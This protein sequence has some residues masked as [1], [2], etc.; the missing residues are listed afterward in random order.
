MKNAAKG[1]S[2]LKQQSLFAYIKKHI[3]HQIV[4]VIAREAIKSQSRVV[5]LMKDAQLSN[6]CQATTSA[7][8]RSA[9]SA[10]TV[11]IL[12]QVAANNRI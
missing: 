8:V 5:K 4:L 11:L 10:P 3:I 12:Y 6:S 7:H 1:S 9:R 2:K